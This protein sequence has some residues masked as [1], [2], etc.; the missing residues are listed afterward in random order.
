M[1]LDKSSDLSIYFTTFYKDKDI[2]VIF[3]FSDFWKGCGLFKQF[4]HYLGFPGGSDDKESA[5]NAGDLASIP[6]SGRS[7]GRENGY[8]LQHSCLENRIDRGAWQAT[9][10][11]ATKSQTR[12]SD[13][14][15]TLHRDAAL[16]P[17]QIRPVLI[18][19]LP[20]TPANLPLPTT[21][22]SNVS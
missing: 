15:F 9:V 8:P 11:A 13:Y 12:L 20:F 10:H 18:K 21:S 3:I 4:L 22:S 6:G 1:T 14:H 17:T 5:C 16:Y 19:H 2:S 7:P